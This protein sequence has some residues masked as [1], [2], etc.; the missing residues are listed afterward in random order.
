MTYQIKD[1]QHLFE[2]DRSRAVM[3]CSWLRLPNK[4]DGMGFRYVL[5]LS[6]GL[7]VLG[8]WMLIVE[9]CSQQTP[10]KPLMREGWLTDDGT[11]EGRPWSAADMAEM[12]GKPTEQIQCALN[13]LTAPKPGWI[14]VHGQ[15]EEASSPPVPQPLQLPI[16][17][18][19]PA[20]TNPKT[21]ALGKRD[22]DEFLA[23][24]NALGRPF[25]QIERMTGERLKKLTAR[26]IDPWWREHYGA[27]LLEAPG[28]PFLRG[29]NDRGWIM[30]FD[31]F[32][33]ESSVTRIL[34]GMGKGRAET[35]PLPGDEIA[36]AIEGA[37]K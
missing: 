19:P 35:A 10:R 13:V 17:A 28:R 26:L 31:F 6:N 36:K 1:W 9:K 21:R 4:Q 2:N 12:W 8:V 25:P 37:G 7:A 23:R 30:D 29:D 34:E 18:I 27:A 32:M 16:D 24:W 22:V 5:G 15:A 33:R 20:P 14:V 3:R 11:P